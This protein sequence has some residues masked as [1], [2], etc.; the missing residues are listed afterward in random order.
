MGWCERNR[1]GIQHLQT[2][3]ITRM[4]LRWTIDKR[5]REGKV[6][7]TLR[8]RERER[9]GGK[10]EVILYSSDSYYLIRNLFLGRRMLGSARLGCNKPEL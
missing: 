5:D 7:G 6:N 8:E 4:V 3:V 1:S 10:E 2:S 9:D